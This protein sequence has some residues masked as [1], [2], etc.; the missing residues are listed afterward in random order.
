MGQ[1]PGW[2][3]RPPAGVTLV[4]EAQD[5]PPHPCPP[6]PCSG[7]RPGWTPGPLGPRS[8]QRL[9]WIPACR[10]HAWDR[11]PRMEPPPARATLRTEARMD[12]PPTGAML[13]TEARMDTPSPAGA[14]LGTEAQD[15][16]PTPAHQGH[17]RDRGQDGR[18]TPHWGT[19]P[20]VAPGHPEPR[21]PPPRH[22]LWGG[23]ASSCH[24]PR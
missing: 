4:T 5:G 22:H 19:L 16:P 7:Q 12:P 15:G 2:T 9:G 18:P 17:A 20:S 11:G 24:T 8:G 6:G 1:K 3:P 21:P 23:C 10:G 14:T 13:G